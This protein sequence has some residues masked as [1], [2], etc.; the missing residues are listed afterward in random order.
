VIH[1]GCL[2]LDPCKSTSD[3]EASAGTTRALA[4]RPKFRGRN[5]EPSHSDP[6][7]TPTWPC[8]LRQLARANYTLYTEQRDSFVALYFFKDLNLSTSCMQQS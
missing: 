1:E 6:T 4:T 8:K 7:R 3:I 5:S 2:L